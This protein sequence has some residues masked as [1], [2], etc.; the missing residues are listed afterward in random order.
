MFCLTAQSPD[1]SNKDVSV[2]ND[3]SGATV[4][5]MSP[6]RGCL[7]PEVLSLFFL[8]VKYLKQTNK[9]VV[10]HLI[11]SRSIDPVTIKRKKVMQA[12]QRVICRFIH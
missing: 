8:S 5:V 4:K 11:P 2:A 12:D 10:I 3:E 7:R 9:T 6:F 1:A